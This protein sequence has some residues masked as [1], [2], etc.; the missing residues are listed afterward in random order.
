MSSHKIETHTNS[1]FQQ[2]RKRFFCWLGLFHLFGMISW[3]IPAGPLHVAHSAL[4]QRHPGGSGLPP[5]GG[6][7]PRRPEAAQHP[8]ERRRRVLQAHRLRP[9]LQRGKPGVCARVCVGVW[10]GG[11]SSGLL[12]PL[13]SSRMSSTSRQTG[14]E[15]PRPSSRTAWPKP[16]WRWRGA[17]RR[18]WTSGVWGSSCWRCSQ[19]SNSKTPFARR[20][21]R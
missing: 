6:L 10:H 13:A 5:P 3:Q 12:N 1:H 9:Q 20:S 14:T 7:R 21:G 8:L 17:A 19:E 18:P 2:R 11:V 4:R 16:G 15:P